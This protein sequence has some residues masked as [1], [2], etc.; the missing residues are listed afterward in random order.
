MSENSAR[1]SRLSDSLRSSDSENDSSSVESEISIGSLAHKPDLQTLLQNKTVFNYDP[2]CLRKKSNWSKTKPEYKFDDVAFDPELMNKDIHTHSSK[3]ETLLKRIADLDKRDMEKD[4]RMY[5]HFIFSDI[6][7]GLYG[8]KL[9]AGAL[10]AKGMHLGYTAEPL[11]KPTKTKTHGKITLDDDEKLLKTKFNNFYLLSSVAVYNQPISVEMKKSILRKFN[12]RP[13]NVYGELARIIVMDSGYKEGIDLFDIK[14]VHIYEPQTTMAD[15]KQVIGRGTRTCGQKGLTFHPTKGWPLYVYIYDVSIPNEL[16]R[17]MLGSPTVF[18]LYM[19]AMN[20]DFR[21]FNFQ[22][23]LER[24]TVYGSVDYELN[25]DIHNFS[26]SP[27]EDDMMFGGA[28]RKFV[29]DKKKSSPVPENPG[30]GLIVRPDMAPNMSFEENR[31]FIHTYF[32]DF[33][34]KDI[35]MENNCVEKK[36]GGADLINYTPTQGFIQSYFTPQLPLKGMLLWHS[37]GTGKTCSAIAAASSSFERAGYTILWVTRTTLKNDI[38][39][40]MFDQ[41]CNESIRE[42]IRRGVKIPDEQPKRMRMLSNSWSIRPMS[43]KQFSNLVSKQ[44]NFYEA[45]VKRNGEADPLRKT[46]LIIDEAHKL[47]GGED[48]STIERPDMN[49]LMAALQNSYMVSGA[50]SVRLLLM[51]ATPITGNPMEL[52]KLINLTKPMAEH[53]PEEFPDFSNKYLNEEGHFTENGEK[54]YLDDIAGHVSYLNREKDARQFSQPIVKFVHSPLVDN[55]KEVAKLDKKLFREQMLGDLADLQKQVEENNNDIDSE[56]KGV[57][58]AKFSFLKSKCENLDGKAKTAC[59]KIV[60]EHIKEIVKEAKDSIQIIKDNIKTLKQ[61]IRERKE[62]RR[63]ILQAMKDN[64]S[65]ETAKK[66]EELK[67]STYYTI[68]YQCGKKVTSNDQLEQ[69]IK[70]LP[71]I[72]EL[73]NGVASIDAKIVRAKQELEIT[74]N[75]HKNR[76]KQIKELMKTDIT[77]DERNLLA[78]V[79]REQTK[80]GN[81][82]IREAEKKMNETQKKIADEKRK[83]M[84]TRKRMVTRIKK[85]ISE[86][87]KEQKIEA[88]E[89]ERAEKEAEKLRQKQGIYLDEIKNNYLKGIVEKHKPLIDKELDEKADE[90]AQMNAVKQAKELAKAEKAQANETKKRQKA[91]EADHKKT[92]KNHK[93]LAKAAEKAQKEAQKN[94][95]KAQKEAEKR[96]KEAEKLEKEAQKNAEKANKERAKEFEKRAKE[97]E[98]MA[99]EQEK[100]EKEAQK[101]AEKHAK[102]LAKAE[103]AQAAATKKMHAEQAKLNKTMKKR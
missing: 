85:R 98:R 49:A 24:N 61:S 62:Y 70:T 43:Y 20:I 55:V 59:E 41:V 66:L 29:Y 34:W 6:K 28:H 83:V 18:D 40:N 5:K 39:K 81:A 87:V 75:A 25:R 79:I 45:L 57:N 26:I 103:K 71:N 46:L 36:S 27:D 11:E 8:A 102:E 91:I 16:Q 19:K 73:D 53:M 9:I 82:K 80:S 100:R 94:A 99:K 97:Q 84:Q 93:D 95:E 10:L 7:T 51:T 90:F 78:M 96:H 23:D 52:I 65:E 17:Q 4:G 2:V 3:L 44:N 58:A 1:S 35:K 67:Q 74:I 89:I 54:R 15:Q 60:R 64:D 88:K 63:D 14:Y 12:E 42:Q 69:A 13:G 31:K 77:Q 30:I 33:A 101:A 21:L 38:W 32:K 76:L 86:A 50:D 48:L 37:V 68:M 72:E 56:L 22:R 47:Y 92:M